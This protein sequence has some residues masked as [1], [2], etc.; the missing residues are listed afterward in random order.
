[1]DLETANKHNGGQFGN[2]HQNVKCIHLWLN[3]F[4]FKDSSNKILHVCK[5]TG[6][7]SKITGE[8]GSNYRI[9]FNNK[10]WK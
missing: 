8:Q 10:I 4:T 9:V 7:Q 6:E 5:I 1:M 2:I 3:N